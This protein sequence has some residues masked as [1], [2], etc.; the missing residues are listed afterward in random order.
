MKIILLTACLTFLL[1]DLTFCQNAGIGTATPNASAQVDITGTGRGVLIPRMSSSAI[2]SIGHPAKGLLVYDTAQ[3]LLMVNMGSA[4]A[5]NWQTIVARS[6]WSVTGNG[7]INPAT[8]FIGTTDKQPFKFRVNNVRAGLIDSASQNTLMGYS[9]YYD[10]YPRNTF[11]GTYNTAFGEN[12]MYLD[13]FNN[14]T[15]MGYRAMLSISSPLYPG[16]RYQEDDCA[17]GS[18]ALSQTEYSDGNTGMGYTALGSGVEATASTAVGSGSMINSNIGR[19]NTAIGAG[20]NSVDGYY[21]TA[22]GPGALY[23][24]VK[25]YFNTAMGYFAM[26]FNRHAEHNTSIGAYSLYVNNVGDNLLGQENTA[27]GYQA[28]Y[29]NE[30]GE[31]NT[32]F[33]NLALYNLQFDP[34][35]SQ[36]ACSQNTAVGY[37]S[38]YSTFRA[39]GNTAIGYNS[40]PNADNGYY[41]CFIGSTI[42]AAY[43]GLYNSIIIGHGNSFTDVNM[44]RVGNPFTTS[45]GGPVGWSNLSDGRVKKNIKENIPGIDFIRKLRPVTYNINLDAMNTFL[46]PVAGKTNTNKARDPGEMQVMKAAYAAKEQIVYT[47]L[48]AQ[49]A[50]QAARETGYDFSGVDAPKSDK[51]LYAL[52]YS[53]FVMPLIK[54]MQEQQQ[55][56]KQLQIQLNE[57]KALVK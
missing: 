4:A 13:S 18:M 12:T 44:M 43:P 55:L 8:D 42:D 10:P 54:T 17:F 29:S 56:I 48:V 24:N 21:N 49:E 15:A 20:L 32:A 40:S 27:V 1:P 45:I 14:C 35:H 23:Q 36:V 26:Y 3:N 2:R 57:L 50:E 7:G 46:P 19:L 52:R 9:S 53:D 25:A 41:N 31:N 22:D 38:L 37:Q 34:T 39:D 51:D 5:P 6:G 30:V 47:G 28:L 11:A 16:Y 33:G